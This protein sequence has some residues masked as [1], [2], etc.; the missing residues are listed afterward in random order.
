MITAQWCKPGTV[1]PSTWIT[2]FS[3]NSDTY[4]CAISGGQADI[5][6]K[7]E[8][9]CCRGAAQRSEDECFH[10]CKPHAKKLNDWAACVGDHVYPDLISFGT[11]CNSIGD[12]ERK[13]H[14]KNGLKLRPGPDPNSGVALSTSWKLGVVVGIVAL[15]QAVC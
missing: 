5:G 3:D 12:L 6:Q 2:G 8:E 9:N 14:E 4:F 1:A 13:N 7:M 10:W 15:L 11:S